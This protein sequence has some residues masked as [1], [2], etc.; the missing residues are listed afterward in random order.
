MG[1]KVPIVKLFRFDPPQDSEK[2]QSCQSLATVKSTEIESSMRAKASR[3]WA[4]A[5]ILFRLAPPKKEKQRL[6][7]IAN[8]TIGAKAPNLLEF[9]AEAQLPRKMEKQPKYKQIV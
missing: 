4:K 5:R 3:F 6:S 9:G 1:A 2:T 8:A 7:T